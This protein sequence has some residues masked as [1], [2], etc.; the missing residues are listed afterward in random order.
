V[1]VGGGW[2]IAPEPEPRDGPRDKEKAGK[3]K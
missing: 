1:K 3:G 2:K